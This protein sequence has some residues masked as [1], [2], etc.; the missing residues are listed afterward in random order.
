MGPAP[1]EMT[2][3]LRYL[4]SRVNP[5]LTRYCARRLRA[6]LFSGGRAASAFGSCPRCHV[7]E[8]P[9]ASNRVIADPETADSSP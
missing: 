8:L 7:R 6:R 1:M 4:T 5:V 9:A 2:L 3:L